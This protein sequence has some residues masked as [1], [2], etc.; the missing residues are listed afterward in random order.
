MRVWPFETGFKTLTEADLEGVAVVAAEVYPSL[1]K[2]TA[3]PGEIKDLTQVRTLAEHFAK[4]DEAG[5]LGAVFD[6]PKGLSEGALEAAATEEGWI[7][8]A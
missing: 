6:A 7:L 4:L 3:T 5:K 1:L 2:I 8:G